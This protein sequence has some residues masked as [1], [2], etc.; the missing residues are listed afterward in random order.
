M[1]VSYD[2]A[3]D[4]ASKQKNADAKVRNSHA[5]PSAMLEQARVSSLH[6]TGSHEWNVF[7]QR[8][9]ALVDAERRL[10]TA[11]AESMSIPNLTS[12]QIMQAQRHM[13][14]TKARID[15]WEQVMNLPKEIMEQSERTVMTQA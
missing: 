12:E 7:L 13:L 10:L 1:R 15:A 5:F 4:L 6:L 9:Q 11:M 3:M 2:E 14:V 8:I